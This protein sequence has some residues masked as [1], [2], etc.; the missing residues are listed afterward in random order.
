[1][2]EQQ[3]KQQTQQQEQPE[4]PEQRTEQEQEQPKQSKESTKPDLPDALT[5]LSDSVFTVKRPS[6]VSMVLESQKTEHLPR[7]VVTVQTMAWMSLPDYGAK[8]RIP[9][10][11]IPEIY[12]SVRQTELSEKK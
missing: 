5:I 3:P 11:A 12:N 6:A 8:C 1:M 7:A 9:D 4:Q 2:S 10:E